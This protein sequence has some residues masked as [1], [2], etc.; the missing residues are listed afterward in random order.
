[1]GVAISLFVVV[2]AAT[3]YLMMQSSWYDT[4]ATLE[5]QRTANLGMERLFRG[6]KANSDSA[7]R[8]LLDAKS[9]AVDSP[10][11]IRFT[12]GI[13]SKERS[14][15]LQDNKLMYDPDTSA[16]SNELSILDNVSTLTFAASAPNP[17]KVVLINLTISKIVKGIDKTMNLSSVAVLRNG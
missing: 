9:F 7:H 5:I 3:L 4:S 6:F 14:F 15:Y 16:S 10:G 12:S 11:N 13:D 8:G 1:M 2:I 17:T